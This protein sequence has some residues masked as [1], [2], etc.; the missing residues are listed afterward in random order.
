MA[1]LE[2]LRELGIE[3]IVVGHD[4]YQNRAGEWC[5]IRHSD[6]WQRV[7]Y[8]SGALIDN[9]EKV[10]CVFLRSD[11]IEGVVRVMQSMLPRLQTVA[12]LKDEDARKAAGDGLLD[13]TYPLWRPQPAVAK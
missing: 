8:Y 10:S 4:V 3:V 12:D 2:E 9:G 1:A 5:K 11:D 6:L 13:Q 7:A